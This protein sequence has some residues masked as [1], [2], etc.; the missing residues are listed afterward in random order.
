LG[1]EQSKL[2]FVQ[3]APGNIQITLKEKIDNTHFTE[4]RRT[5]DSTNRIKRNQAQKMELAD[6]IV[7]PIVKK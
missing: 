7:K 1:E 4:I 5:P 3:L 2:L 6:R